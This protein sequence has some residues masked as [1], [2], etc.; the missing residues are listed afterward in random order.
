[1]DS[2]PTELRPVYWPL[3]LTIEEWGDHIF[4]KTGPLGS[5]RA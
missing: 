4:N 3:M 2:M 1:M 5:F